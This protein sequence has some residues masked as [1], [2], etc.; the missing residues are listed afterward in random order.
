[1]SRLPINPTRMELLR[2]RKRLVV[3][4]RG[5]KL[6]KDKLDGLMKEFLEISNKYKTSRLIVDEELP[7]ILKLFVIADITSS[8]QITENAL[9]STKQDLELKINRNR[10][11]GVI[12]PKFEFSFGETKG[13]YSFIHTSPELDRAISSLKDFMTELLKMAELEETVRLMAVEIEKTRRRVNAL[14]YTVI[15]RMQ[16]TVKYITNKLDEME[17]SNTARLMKIKALR[18]AQE[19]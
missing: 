14:E 6:L 7:Q 12:V 15:P 19:S 18:L 17:R 16:E 9:E 5:H 2:L 13:M 1:M 3:A 10:I 11:M 8:R 4:Q